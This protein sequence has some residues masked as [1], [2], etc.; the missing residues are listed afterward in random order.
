MQSI[1]HANNIR[2]YRIEIFVPEAKRKYGYYVFP[3]L[4]KDKLIGRIDMKGQRSDNRLHVTGL[5]LEPGIKYTKGR[6]KKLMS[7]L[8]RHARFIGL[9]DVTFDDGFLKA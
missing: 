6:E 8:N 7:E 2:F 3:L 1:D 9:E 5:W 4:E